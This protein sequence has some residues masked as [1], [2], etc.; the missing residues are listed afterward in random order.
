VQAAAKKMGIATN[1]AAGHMEAFS[2]ALETITTQVSTQQ[3]GRA[4]G[5]DAL[6]LINESEQALAETA[7]DINE[8]IGLQIESNTHMVTAFQK[9][10]GTLGTITSELEVIAD[11]IS[12]VPGSST[13]QVG[14]LQSRVGDT[15]DTGNTITQDHVKL[16]QTA[17]DPMKPMSERIQ[18]SEILNATGIMDN[19][20][21]KTTLQG[22]NSTL[23]SESK[24][25]STAEKTEQDTGVGK[26]MWDK[27]KDAVPGLAEGGTLGAGMLGVVG[28]GGGMQNAELLTGPATVTPMTTMAN[29]LQTQFSSMTNQMQNAMKQDATGVPQALQDVMADLKAVAPKTDDIDPAQMKTQMSAMKKQMQ[30][31]QNS[32]DLI[33][34]MQQLIEINRKTM[35]NTNKQFK[36]STDNMRGI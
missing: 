31:I 18:A 34:M 4:P 19:G 5:Q 9:A 35:E 28:E 22:I 8:Q 32:P 17:L 12:G 25:S 11:T 7:G 16:L 27:I 36:L 1:T 29:A 15:T 26:S 21:L 13:N 3:M 2:K 30:E 33:Q 6:K 23:L 10:T 14:D 20:M 24:S